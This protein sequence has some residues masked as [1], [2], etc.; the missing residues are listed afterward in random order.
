MNYELIMLKNAQRMKKNIK[1]LTKEMQLIAMRSYDTTNWK[2]GTLGQIDAISELSSEIEHLVSFCNSIEKALLIIPSKYRA[3]LVAVYFK[4]YDKEQLGKRF[5]V[6]RSTVYRKLFV[7]RKLF[8]EALQS[9]GC[10]EE[11][12]KALYCEKDSPLR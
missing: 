9:I 5:G 3:L 6:S 1:I 4:N 10:T 8:Y 2:N 7:A 12:F 11:W